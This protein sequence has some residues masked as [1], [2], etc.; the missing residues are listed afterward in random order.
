M[1]LSLQNSAFLSIY[2]SRL[3]RVPTP[4]LIMVMPLSLRQRNLHVDYGS[5]NDVWTS[6]DMDIL[7]NEL[8]AA[9]ATQPQCGVLVVV[10]LSDELLGW[11]P[12]PRRTEKADGSTEEKPRDTHRFTH[13]EV[14]A[15]YIAL[16][17]QSISKHSAPTTGMQLTW[18]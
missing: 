7:V 13:L 1:C 18:Q 4:Q 15:P 14:R 17:Y 8:D 11:T 16:K 9:H 2:Q 5:E 6:S 3:E 12:P 10:R